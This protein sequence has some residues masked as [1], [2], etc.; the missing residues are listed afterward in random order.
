MAGILGAAH[1]IPLAQENESYYYRD[2]DN[3][4][5]GKQTVQEVG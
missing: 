3:Y 5:A 1:F 4:G 2:N